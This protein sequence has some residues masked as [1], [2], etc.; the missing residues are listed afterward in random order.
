[1]QVEMITN[2]RIVVDDL[3]N[4]SETQTST[5][6]QIGSRVIGMEKKTK[7]LVTLDDL[8]NYSRA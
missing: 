5:G 4:E 7:A 1:M 2:Q 6:R 3:T 8:R